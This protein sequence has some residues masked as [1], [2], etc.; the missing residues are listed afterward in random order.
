MRRHQARGHEGGGHPLGVG[1]GGLAEAVGDGAGAGVAEALDDHRRHRVEGGQ[2]GGGGGHLLGGVVHAGDD[3]QP[4]LGEPVQGVE[5]A[6]GGEDPVV[7]ASGERAVD[8]G[9]EGLQVDHRPVHG[10]GQH[11]PHLGGR[12]AVRV[13]QAGQAG[14]GRV[15]GQAAEEVVHGLPLQRGLAARDGDPGEERGPLGDLAVELGH[16]PPTGTGAG[17]D[18]DR[19]GVVARDAAERAALEEH[20]VAVAGPVDAGGVD[21]VSDE[22]ERHV[23]GCAPAGGGG[24]RGGRSRRTRRRAPCWHGGRRRRRPPAGGHGGGPGSR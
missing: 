11:L 21:D 17:T 13:D 24:R 15:G 20:H 3:E 2:P 23:R 6:D 18:A 1:R 14:G 8:L 22:G 10:R 19:V 5:L 7:R 16:V 4:H 12:V 9:V